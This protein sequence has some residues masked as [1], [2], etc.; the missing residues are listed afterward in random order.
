MK[1]LL[2]PAEF[3]FEPGNYH[4]TF[5]ILKRVP[6]EFKVLCG[7]V[8]PD[9]KKIPQA[10]IYELGKPF[11]LYPFKIAFYGLKFNIQI[12]HHISPFAIG[13]DF[14][15]LALRTDKPF[16]IGPIEIPH[17]LFDDELEMLKIPK[18]LHRLKDSRLRT[19]MSVKTMERCDV[20]VAVNKQTKEYLLNFVDKKNIK[21][22]PLGVDTGVFKFSSVPNNHEILTVGRHIKRKGHDYLIKA[23]T[24]VIKEYP[25]ARLNITSN[26]PQ[27]PHLKNLAK[28]LNLN[29]YIIFHDR[30]NDEELLRLYKQCRVFCHPSLSEGFCHTTLE[31]MATGR[32]VVS[33]NTSGSDMV[34]NGKTGFLVPTA[35]SEAIADNILK[36]LSDD[37][38]THKMGIEARKRV[39]EEYDWN[40]IAEEYYKLYKEMI[41]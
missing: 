1:V 17:L 4:V 25:D 7:V 32:P 38:L 31:A 14:N 19:T 27:T 23:M 13:K 9:I 35:D 11:F 39:E 30:V 37:K 36:I 18:I 34:E 6:A 24:K 15:L 22:T 2:A 5:N 8:N 16:I 3:Y 41:T 26:G 12:I 40:I 21:V 33:T 28:K 29:K 20:A 10:E